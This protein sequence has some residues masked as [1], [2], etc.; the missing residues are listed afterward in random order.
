LV[1]GGL[2]EA[3]IALLIP[4]E[5]I[6]PEVGSRTWNPRMPA[7]FVGMPKAAMN[8]DRFFPVAERNVGS[9]WHTF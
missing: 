5:L 1:C 9:T 4:V 6:S 7:T 3:L 8:E 2:E